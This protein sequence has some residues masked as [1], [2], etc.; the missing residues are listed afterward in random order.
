MLAFSVETYIFITLPA[1]C[2]F[3]TTRGFFEYVSPYNFIKALSDDTRLIK[4]KVSKKMNYTPL[5]KYFICVIS[6]L[7]LHF[8]IF[9]GFSG[10]F[11]LGLF[12]LNEFRLLMSHLVLFFCI[13]I[14]YLLYCLASSNFYASFDFV[15]STVVIFINLCFL[16]FS[17]NMLIFFLF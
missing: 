1:L 2:L 8:I 10:R 15:Y 6:L 13:I 14:L 12:Y 7:D 3:F 16:F 4:A 5:I 17:N 11:F 9:R